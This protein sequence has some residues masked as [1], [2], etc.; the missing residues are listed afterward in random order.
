MACMSGWQY[1]VP[2]AD[3]ADESD[4]LHLFHMRPTKFS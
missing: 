1:G 2:E 4:S 3:F